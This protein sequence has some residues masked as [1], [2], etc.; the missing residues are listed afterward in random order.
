MT[1]IVYFGEMLVASLLAIVLLAISQLRMSSDALLF[2]GG[3]VG[4]TLAEY[5][6]HRFVLH[7]F[8]PTEHRLHHANPDGAVLTI[9]WQ[10]WICFALVYL[11]VGGAFVAGALVA[12]TWYLF[13]HHCAHHGPA[14]L[15][16]SLLEH[17]QSHHRFA[18][19]NY[20]VST[21]LWDRIFGTMLR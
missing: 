19:G 12:Y 9:F 2:A 21:T 16:L 1:A 5:I 14:S 11:I 18:S 13:V 8:A 17:H 6:V 10:I 20:G 7:G 15:P 4:W 3:V